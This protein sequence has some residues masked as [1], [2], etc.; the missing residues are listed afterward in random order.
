MKLRIARG[1]I[2]NGVRRLNRKR[3]LLVPQRRLPRYLSTGLLV[4]ALAGSGSQIVV[5]RLHALPADAAFRL[6]DSV[7]TVEQLDH[8][9]QLLG[10]LYGVQRPS[11]PAKVDQFTRDSAKAVAVST[12]LDRAAADQ[13]IVIADKTASDQLDKVISQSYPG[14]RQEFVTKLG[15]LGVS[16]QD[17]LDEIKRQLANAQL[18]DSVTKG[19]APVTDDDVAKAFQDRKQQMVRPEARDLRNIVVGTEAEAEQVLQRLRSGTDFA[20]VAGQTSLDQSTKDKGGDLGP[21]TADQLDKAYADA[22]FKAPAG[23]VFGPVQTQNGW[24]IGQVVSVT[25]AAPLTFDQVKD[26]LKTQLANERKSALW[27][28]W[29]AGRIKAAGVQYADTYRPADPDAPP[30]DLP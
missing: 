28:S 12:I 30:A 1:V 11:D 6:D 19:A 9:V 22:A 8:R 18:Y 23:T 14:G 10:A 7:T 16:E 5:D 24:N 15:Q 26:Q 17:V 21:M 13:G 29:L 2:E 25:P 4:V 20:A 3:R 27:N